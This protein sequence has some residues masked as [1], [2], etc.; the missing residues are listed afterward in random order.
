MSIDEFEGQIGIQIAVQPVVKSVNQK[1][2]P[3]FD[4]DDLI[5]LHMAVELPMSIAGHHVE[6]F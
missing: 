1:I 4:T 5:W 6:W 2:M 3:V